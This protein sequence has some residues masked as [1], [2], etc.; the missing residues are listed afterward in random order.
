MVHSCQ[1]FSSRRSSSG[2]SPPARACCSSV[3]CSAASAWLTASA[4][5]RRSVS[6]GSPAANRIANIFFCVS[7][8]FM[9]CPRFG[10]FGH[11]PCRG[12]IRAAGRFGSAETRWLRRRRRPS[13]G[14]PAARPSLSALLRCYCRSR[15]RPVNTSSVSPSVRCTRPAF[16]SSS[17]A[18]KVA[19][20]SLRSRFSAQMLCRLLL[21]RR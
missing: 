21:P 1:L 15:P 9:L 13:G 6:S 5:A 16:S 7:V 11:R 14:G 18:I 19:T 20:S 8:K 2:S 10:Q 17:T 12:Q 4:S 3:H